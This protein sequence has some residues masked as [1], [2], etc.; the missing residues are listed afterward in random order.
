MAKTLQRTIQAQRQRY[1]ME[2]TVS[3]A[4]AMMR[5][6]EVVALYG[7]ADSEVGYCDADIARYEAK[8]AHWTA[9]AAA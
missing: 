6:D 7:A 5:R 9:K 2:Y 1:A 8:V 3:L 4:H